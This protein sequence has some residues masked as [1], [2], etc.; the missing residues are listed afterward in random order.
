MAHEVA[1]SEVPV[2]GC[3]VNRRWLYT[4]P[5]GDRAVDASNYTMDE[6]SIA[7]PAEGEALVEAMFWR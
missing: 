1:G 3:R 4:S 2:K 7:D 5:P 6:C